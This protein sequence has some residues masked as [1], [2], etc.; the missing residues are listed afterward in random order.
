MRWTH[1][2]Q[3]PS[4]AVIERETRGSTDDSMQNLTPIFQV[5]LVKDL[6]SKIFWLNAKKSQR[7]GIGLNDN[8]WGVGSS[9]DMKEEEE[10]EAVSQQ[11]LASAT[12]M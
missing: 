5:F 11:Q 10:E 6:T 3:N 8:E 4:P 1:R 2:P 12:V 9:S 7:D